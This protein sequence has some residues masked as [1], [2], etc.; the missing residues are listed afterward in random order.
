MKAAEF[1]KILKP[2]VE[3]TVKEVLFK[4]GVL[5]NIV[6]EVARGLNKTILEQQHTSGN[7]ALLKAEEDIKQKEDLLEQ[8]RQERIKKLNE[9]SKFGDVFK[10]TRRLQ[11]QSHGALTGISSNDKGVDISAI[12]KLASGKW[13]RLM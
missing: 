10:G 13:K 11:D 9:S 2:L 7:N 4:E 3:Q 12:E 8:Q 6:A 1:K 5:S